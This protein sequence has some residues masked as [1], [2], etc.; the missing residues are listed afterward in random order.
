MTSTP[1]IF[2]W[3]N[4]TEMGILIQILPSSVIALYIFMSHNLHHFK[5]SS[6]V[7][8]SLYSSYSILQLYGGDV[9]TRLI[10]GTPVKSALRM[11]VLRRV[12]I[13]SSITYSKKLSSL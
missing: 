5:Y 9:T 11:S 8:A 2:K 4:V 3:S 6:Y 13:A 1:L 12:I 10:G 7:M